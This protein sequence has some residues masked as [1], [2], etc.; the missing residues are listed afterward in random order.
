MIMNLT[1]RT[2]VLKTEF[3][4]EKI[5]HIQD[6]GLEIIPFVFRQVVGT[7]DI[8][9][10]RTNMPASDFCRTTDSQINENNIFQYAVFN[11]SGSKKARKAILLLHGLNERM[12]DKYYTWAED[13]AVHCGV[14]VILF[15]IAFHMNRTPSSWFNPRL[16]LP[17]ISKRK[18]SL[19]HLSNSSFFNLALSSR[20]T[21]CPER[22]YIS[23]RESIYN[24]LQLLNDIKSGDHP[25]FAEDCKVNIFAY[26][27]GALL[28]QTMLIANPHDLF[29]DTKLFTFCGGSIFSEMNGVSKDIMDSAAYES[30]RRY[31]IDTFVNTTGD[32]IHDA[33]RSMVCTESLRDKRENFFSSASD[34]IMMMTLKKDTVI[35]TQGVKLA[36]GQKVSD[37]MIQELDFPFQYS[38]QIPFPAPRKASLRGES[39]DAEDVYLSFRKIFDR[40]E[41]FL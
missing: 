17:W 36:V 22:F 21:S 26:S 38:H 28:S 34:R 14:P 32:C 11:P 31:Y 10:L 29:T 16:L 25:L 41:S 7:N 19:V 20:L 12:W 18:E 30:I 6:T 24:I 5:G 8:D 33:F 2:N 13:I 40:A 23:G 4:F 1:E 27:I 37:S 9:T 39:I 35:P 3:S 15:P